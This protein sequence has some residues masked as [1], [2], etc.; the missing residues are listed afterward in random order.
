MAVNKQKVCQIINEKIDRSS[1]T[2]RRERIGYAFDMI[3]VDRENWYKGDQDYAVA[4][5]Y[6][7][8]R[9]LTA[10]TGTPGLILLTATNFLYSSLKATLQTI[11]VEQLLRF[12]KGPV[13]P[14]SIDEFIWAERGA[15][16]GLGDRHY[17]V[18]SPSGKPNY[19]SAC[20]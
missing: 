2:S 5:H 3:S 9:W 14:V 20:Q 1:G 7:F 12:G 11:G 15:N 19:P 10:W 16:D 6:L 4:E 8:A 18:S 17:L 13:T